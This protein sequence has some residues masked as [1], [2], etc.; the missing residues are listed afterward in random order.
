M[1]NN[2]TFAYEGRAFVYK[3][4]EK[5]AKAKKNWEKAAIL[6]Q[7]QGNMEQYQEIQQQLRKL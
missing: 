1:G 3:I 7:K 6:C 4:L 5:I 2:Q